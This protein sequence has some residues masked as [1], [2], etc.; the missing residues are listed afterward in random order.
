MGAEADNTHIRAEIAQLDRD[1]SL[2]RNRSQI[3]PITRT[4]INCLM[5]E[6]TSLSARLPDAQ[7]A[8]ANQQARAE[9]QC[10]IFDQ[11]HAVYLEKQAPPLA[12]A[13]QA[14]C[15]LSRCALPGALETE[16]I[17]LIAGFDR[18]STEMSQFNLS[19]G[20]PTAMSRLLPPF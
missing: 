10:A 15:D 1:A 2:L 20:I 8:R 11:G 17:G 9:I 14:L 13:R 18:H 12:I 5:N 19:Q 3:T 4:R 16:I 6:S 7:K